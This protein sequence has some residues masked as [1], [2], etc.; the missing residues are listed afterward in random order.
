MKTSELIKE[1]EQMVT[2]EE[3]NLNIADENRKKDMTK[4]SFSC[5]LYAGKILAYEEILELITKR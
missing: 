1:I 4:S 3:E 2:E 5:G